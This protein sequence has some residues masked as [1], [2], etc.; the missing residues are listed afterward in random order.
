MT[1][2]KNLGVQTSQLEAAAKAAVGLAA[3]YRLDLNSA[4]QL[5]GRASQGQTQMLT[6]Y[7]IILEE[8]LSPQ[9]KFNALL[10][11]GAD[12]FSLAEAQA[13]TASGEIAQMNNAVG[14]YGE[15][16]GEFILPIQSAFV[17]LL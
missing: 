3:K 10:K 6:R 17:E 11:I 9:E 1:Y 13:K 12:S 7:G 5:V 15:V 14:D 8:T 16:L 4:M 2:A